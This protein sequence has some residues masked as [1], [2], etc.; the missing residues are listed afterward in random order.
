[1]VGTSSLKDT[2]MIRRRKWFRASSA[3]SI[4]GVLDPSIETNF[5]G[6]RQSDSYSVKSCFEL[7]EDTM[8]SNCSHKS[9]V[10]SPIVLLGK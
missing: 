2:L 7:L 1:M 3:Q 6:K 5:G 8:E 9:G 10:L 4:L